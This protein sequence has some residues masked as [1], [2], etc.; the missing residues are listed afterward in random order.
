M[1]INKHSRPW[2]MAGRRLFRERL[3]SQEHKENTFS[4]EGN[5]LLESRVESSP[6]KFPTTPQPI[7]SADP[8]QRLLTVLGR[9]NRFVSL[10]ESGNPSEGWSDDCMEQ[11]ITG[12]E[13]ALAESWADVKHALTDTARILQS[14]ED[15]GS[16]TR[17]LPFLKKSYEVLC[18]MVGDL[19]VGNVRS[20]VLD[21]WNNLNNDAIAELEHAGIALVDDGNEKQTATVPPPPVMMA[22]FAPVAKE[23]FI[24][25][26][27]VVKQETPVFFEDDEP[28]A[29]M[30]ESAPSEEVAEVDDAFAD[31]PFEAPCDFE[32]VSDA[33]SS[34]SNDEDFLTA[35]LETAPAE[36][37]EEAPDEM[38]AEPLENKAIEE[39]T[40]DVFVV[41]EDEAD[42][43]AYDIAAPEIATETAQTVDDA[44]V[45]E[46]PHDEGVLNNIESDFDFV[47]ES[48]ADLNALPPVL[49][50]ME[51]EVKAEGEGEVEV[52]TESIEDEVAEETEQPIETEPIAGAEPEPEPEV[53]TE[54]IVQ[55]EPEVASTPVVETKVEDPIQA[56]L[57]TAN[58]A[59]AKGDVGEAKI[60][61]LQLAAQMAA[62]E[63]ARAVE[64]VSATSAAL[65]AILTEIHD[66]D[67]VIALAQARM[68]EMQS[69]VESYQ[70]SILEKKDEIES[71]QWEVA[72][73]EKRMV[74]LDEQI[75]VL[76]EKRADEAQLGAELQA[77]MEMAVYQEGQFKEEVQNLKESAQG[78]AIALEHAEKHVA[79]LHENR[80]FQEELILEAEIEV[81]RQQKSLKD[82][83]RTIALVLGLPLEEETPVQ[84]ETQPE[85]EVLQEENP[86]EP[87]EDTANQEAETEQEVTEVVDET[88]QEEMTEVPIGE[89]TDS[90]QIV[91]EVAEVVEQQT[92]KEP[93]VQ[94]H[95]DIKLDAGEVEEET[96]YVEEDIHRDQADFD[97]EEGDGYDEEFEPDWEKLAEQPDYSYGKRSGEWDD[98]AQQELF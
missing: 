37:A 48:N 11:L 32:S 29:D 52:E 72:Q 21:K 31:L 42:D 83:S 50:F 33:S 34:E 20:G 71:L 10:A 7:M 9:F 22:P 75:R 57:Q 84:V 59:I 68:Q 18:L 28:M 60:L 5:T 13:I 30:Q 70:S 80:E 92:V 23:E 69:K 61:A 96:D 4:E 3:K 91:D 2:A 25:D 58:H 65:E 88:D 47:D 41:E 6:S 38:E 1:R 53:E 90:E 43:S 64:K 79:K 24:P 12:I 94:D 8:T 67:A 17:A 87:D 85:I 39:E 66:G 15:A 98:G 73:V 26:P 46:L 40:A 55:E 82:I 74:D 36:A 78:A 35:V 44:I 27:P 14:Y 54:N 19:I 49:D 76:Q 51:Q 77:D 16:P 97:V 63:E 45:D 95:W 56:L 62:L 81:E 93:E 86:V 89:D